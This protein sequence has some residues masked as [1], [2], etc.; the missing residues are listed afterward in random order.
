[1]EQG[2]KYDI[3]ILDPPA[4]IKKKKDYHSGLSAYRK[5]NELALRLLEKN[6]FLLSASCSMHLPDAALQESVQ[7]SARH[8]DRKL[9]LIHRGGHAIDHP[10]H[11]AMPETECLKA[12]LYRMR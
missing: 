1:L 11:P 4:F 2:E 8:V 10:I 12:Q 5:G 3:V 7:Q 9:S 6:G